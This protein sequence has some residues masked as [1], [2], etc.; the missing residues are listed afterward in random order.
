MMQTV[1]SELCTR[2][3]RKDR[4]IIFL[5]DYEYV[6][7]IEQSRFNRNKL[8][9]TKLISVLRKI[10]TWIYWHMAEANIGRLVWYI[11]A[12]MTRFLSVVKLSTA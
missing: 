7:K 10:S 12:V 5:N 11:C 9:P 1:P 6:Q 3:I 2:Q 8:D 4:R